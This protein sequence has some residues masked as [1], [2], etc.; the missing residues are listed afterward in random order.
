MLPM[1]DKIR[2]ICHDLKMNPLSGVDPNRID[3]FR[4]R[5]KALPTAEQIES[6]DRSGLDELGVR[7]ER[8]IFEIDNAR[9]TRTKDFAL[10]HIVDKGIPPHRPPILGS[11]VQLTWLKRALNDTGSLY[12]IIQSPLQSDLEMPDAN[13]EDDIERTIGTSGCP[14]CHNTEAKDDPN[15]P[16]CDQVICMKCGTKYSI[17]SGPSHEYPTGG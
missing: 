16:G 3:D 14:V 2:A 10:R 5:M 6:M 4:A 9:N 7:V 17:S 13:N 8:L 12:D 15:I 11:G 1:R